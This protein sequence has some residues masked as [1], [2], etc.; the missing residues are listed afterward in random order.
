[1]VGPADAASLLGWAR[2]QVWAMEPRALEAMTGALVALSRGRS[3]ELEMPSPEFSSR[4]PVS[5]SEAM[6]AVMPRRRSARRSENAI[7]VL[8]VFGVITYRG[9]FGG[10]STVDLLSDLRRVV[11]DPGVK[12]VIMP[13]DSPG[14]TVSGVPEVA[15]AL[16]A[17]RA[18]KRIVAVVDPFS[19]SAAYWIASSASEIV[20]IPSGETGSIGV[21]ALH[22]RGRLRERPFT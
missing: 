4:S 20:S 21:F 14:G 9:L 18:K 7:A 11:D 5:L 2:S 19:A 10:T 17:A 15:A 12:S 13:I 1:M 22:L 8:P 16:R 6:I 3:S